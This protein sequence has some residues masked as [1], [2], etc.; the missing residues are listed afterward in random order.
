MKKKLTIEEQLK[1]IDEYVIVLEK[2]VVEKD[3]E[4]YAD[5]KNDNKSFEE[6]WEYVYYEKMELAK[7]DRKRR[8]IMPYELSPIPSY[9]DVMTL[10]EFIEAC[11]EGWFIDSDGSGYYGKDGQETNIPIC[12]SDMKHRA[13][14]REF[15][16]VIW[17][18]K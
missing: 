16:S 12:P 7:L 14:R 6:Y 17:Y 15:D 1:K 18:N 2:I 10:D 5:K 9:G 8:M 13:I 4:W 11:K 3:K